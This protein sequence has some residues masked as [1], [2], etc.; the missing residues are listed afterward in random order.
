M[1]VVI[2]IIIVSKIPFRIMNQPETIIGIFKEKISNPEIQITVNVNP[3]VAVRQIF[4]RYSKRHVN[5]NISYTPIVTEKLAV[6]TIIPV[7]IVKKHMRLV[8]KSPDNVT[9]S[10]MTVIM[11]V[12]PIG[13]RIISVIIIYPTFMIPAVPFPVAIPVIVFSV[14]VIPVKISIAVT[15][16]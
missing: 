1:S 16:I 2:I 12:K 4:K 13:I 6:V 3:F 8:N 15:I 5:Q 11:T 10:W 9:E 7:L 14:I